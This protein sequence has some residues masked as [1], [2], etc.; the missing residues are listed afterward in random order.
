MLVLEGFQSVPVIDLAD[1]EPYDTKVQSKVRYDFP[2]PG[3]LFRERRLDLSHIFIKNPNQTYFVNISD[4][5]MSGEEIWAE[6]VVVVDRSAVP[7]SGLNVVAYLDGQFLLRKLIIEINHAV[8]QA[9][10]EDF[11]RIIIE[12]D[13]DFVIWGVVRDVIRPKGFLQ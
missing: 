1:L 10:N 9:S 6:D 13:M 4:D 11:E 3:E 2:L 7:R 5:A 8:L 12:P